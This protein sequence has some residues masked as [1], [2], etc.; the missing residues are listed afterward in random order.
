MDQVSIGETKEA[1]NEAAMLALSVQPGDVA[2]RQDNDTL[3]M[4]KKAPSTTLANW[5]D[6][7]SALS[8]VAGVTS[9]N[10]M[11]G[12]VTLGASDVG[13]V[14]TARTVT[15]GTGLTGGGDLTANRTVA[16]SAASLA[17]LVKADA[18]VQGAGLGLWIGNAAAYAAVSPK[19]ST[20][21]YVVTP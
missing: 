6:L 12:V 18:S 19:L 9:I 4:L 13:A 5:W 16:L 1:A 20:V 7:T 15:A 2:I 14:P 3:W 8:G 17:S 11:T 21:A 10:T